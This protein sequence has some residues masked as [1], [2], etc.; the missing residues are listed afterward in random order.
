MQ[1]LQTDPVLKGGMNSPLQPVY[2]NFKDKE[3]LSLNGKTIAI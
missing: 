3:V 2:I 1:I